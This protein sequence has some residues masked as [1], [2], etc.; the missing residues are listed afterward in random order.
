M[1]Q[2]EYS[3]SCT[4]VVVVVVVVIVVR[5]GGVGGGGGGSGNGVVVVLS[6]APIQLKIDVQPNSNCVAPKIVLATSTPLFSISSNARTVHNFI[7][8]NMY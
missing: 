6:T 5:G 2:T 3:L 1:Q 7:P 4:V 8:Y